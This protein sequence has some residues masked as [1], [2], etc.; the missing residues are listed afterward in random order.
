MYG[1]GQDWAYEAGNPV[2][3]I[4]PDVATRDAW[5]FRG[6]A[7]RALKP[8]NESVMILPAGGKV[9]IEIACHVAHTSYG[10]S[11]SNLSDPLAA[12][13]GNSGAFH[14]G[15]PDEPID[16]SLLSGCALAIADKDEL[17]QVG[18][19]DLAVFSVNQRCVRDRYTPFEVPSRMPACSGKKCICACSRD[20]LTNRTIPLRLDIN[21]LDIDD[22]LLRLANRGTGNFYMTAFDCAV[23][24]GRAP[25]RILPVVDPE[26][27]PS[28]N[29]SCTRTK[30][31]KRPL[32]AY[33]SPS[34]VVWQGNDHR[35]GYHDEW[36][37]VDGPQED[38]FAESVSSTTYHPST[39][40]GLDRP[41]TAWNNGSTASLS[42][43]SK[44]SSSFVLI[45]HTF[46]SGPTPSEPRRNVDPSYSSIEHRTGSRTTLQVTRPD[47]ASPSHYV[48]R[49]TTSAR[50][51]ALGSPPSSS[52]ELVSN[53]AISTMQASSDTPAIGA[54]LKLSVSTELARRRRSEAG[55]TVDSAAAVA[56]S[57]FVLEARNYVVDDLLDQARS[58]TTASGANARHV[59]RSLLAFVFPI[60][61]SSAVL[62][63]S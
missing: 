57:A 44:A 1:V 25:A 19:D 3:P 47:V 16:D 49:M 54:A 8:Q 12:C 61:A 48:S 13:P 18:W 30:G 59:V 55:D 24:P 21:R 22:D 50:S 11:P 4:G 39:S 58:H 36:S 20:D 31:A 35:P 42:S 53:Q 28:S 7:Y 17:D 43:R 62:A 2:D 41:S 40:S 23:E 10:V 52:S 38:I 14:S 56:T 34:N 29:S 27:C 51:T 63:L 5:W 46:C 60:M 45:A 33:N 32:Y 6:P 15:V 37:F 9:D 26:F